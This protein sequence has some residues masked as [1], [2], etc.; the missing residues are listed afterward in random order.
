MLRSKIFPIVAVLLCAT[1]V[2]CAP[3]GQREPSALDKDQALKVV[4]DFEE[5]MRSG[6]GVSDPSSL[7]PLF[8]PDSNDNDRQQRNKLLAELPTG[9]DWQFALTAYAIADVRCGGQDCRVTIRETRDYGDRSARF[10]RQF[11]RLFVLERSQDALRVNAYKHVSSGNTYFGGLS[12][13]EKYSG[14]YP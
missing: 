8:A 14:F 13:S 5:R 10:G 2:S 12:G 7:M 4:T 9:K 3:L 1:A 11:D 6:P